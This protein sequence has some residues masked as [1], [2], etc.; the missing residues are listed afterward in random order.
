MAKQPPRTDQASRL[1]GAS[2]HAIYQA[3]T[4]PAA[5]VQWLPPVGMSA[6]MVE[7]D[8]RPGG[9]YR[10]VLRYDDA[11][12]AG[13][14]GDGQDI[15]EA[16]FTELMPDALVVQSVVFVSDDPDFAGT[17]TM[18]WMLTP[19]GAETEVRIVAENVPPGIGEA[20]HLEGINA[21]LKNLATFLE[22]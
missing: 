21:S 18:R 12:I 3:M 11:A 1:I 13:K 17:M 4:T 15:V 2:P 6:E 22:G 14:A 7:F 5:L 10:M 8:L 20:D 19:F 9:R 16:R